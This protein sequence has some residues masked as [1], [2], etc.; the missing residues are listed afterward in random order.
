MKRRVAIVTLAALVAAV[1]AA[2]LAIVAGSSSLTVPDVV[3]TLLGGGTPA[4]ELIVIDLR[5]PRV[6]GGLLVGAALGLAGALSQTFARNPLATPTSSA[7]PR[8]PRS[9]PSRR[10]CSPAAP[11]RWAPGC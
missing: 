3:R 4:Q 5:L 11:T 9:A 2:L 10:S 7:S 8:A 6:V 1:L